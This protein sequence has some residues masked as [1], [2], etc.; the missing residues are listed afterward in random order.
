M[1]RCVALTKQN[2]QCKNKAK[3]GSDF[4]NVHQSA[5][6]CTGVTLKGLPCKAQRYKTS[7]FCKQHQNQTEAVATDCDL[8]RIPDIL[9]KRQDAVLEYRN[10]LDAYTCE[11]VRDT[12]ELN[13]DHIV[14]IHLL[15]DCYDLVPGNADEKKSLLSF[16]KS[17]ANSIENLN[18]TSKTINH[19]KQ[20]AVKLFCEDYR[21]KHCH[22]DGLR[23]YLSQK[24]FD[25]DL[26]SRIAELTYG[27]MDY[28]TSLL[29]DHE[30]M[31]GHVCDFMEKWPCKV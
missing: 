20:C 2:Q 3:D 7:L 26:C 29:H 16:V 27:S 13:L 28:V 22:V 14:E 24:S 21:T 17:T 18:F 23:H 11:A 30:E 4:C 1:A 12:P 15:R 25:E 9:E 10:S 19:E 31:L 6:Y 5:N 8:F